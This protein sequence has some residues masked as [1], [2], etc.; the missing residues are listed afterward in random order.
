ML[1]TSLMWAVVLSA[2]TAAAD[3][4]VPSCREVQRVR[5]YAAAR[6]LPDVLSAVERERCAEPEPERPRHAQLLEAA[7][8]QRYVITPITY[9]RRDQEADVCREVAPKIR[10]TTAQVREVLVHV[11]RQNEAACALAFYPRVVDPLA[12]EEVYAGMGSQAERE[13]RLALQAAA[14]R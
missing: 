7:D 13:V 10:L 6:G 12:W 11:G 5:A 8:F 9:A 14:R 2:A 3:N 4:E 1:R